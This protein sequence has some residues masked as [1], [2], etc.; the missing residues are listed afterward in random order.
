MKQAFVLKAAAP[1]IAP[2][3]KFLRLIEERFFVY[4]PNAK[5]HAE[6]R[7]SCGYTS[8]ANCLLRRSTR[9]CA[10][11]PRDFLQGGFAA[12]LV[13]FFESVKTVA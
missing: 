2:I 5:G 12:R 1:C 11:P 8:N 13:Q 6:F 9:S 4:A 3:G 10:G 7:T